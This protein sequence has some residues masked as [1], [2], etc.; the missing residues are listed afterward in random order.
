MTTLPHRFWTLSQ[1]RLLLA[2]CAAACAASCSRAPKYRCAV[3]SGCIAALPPG[4]RRRTP[5]SDTLGIKEVA[6]RLS[7][8]KRTGRADA[9]ALT[10]CRYVRR[11][12]RFGMGA[13]RYSFYT[14]AMLKRLQEHRPDY[15]LT[16]GP[17]SL[18]LA[19][20][21]L[22]WGIEA[23]LVFAY[24]LA[25]PELRSHTFVEAWS[26]AR[27]QWFVVDPS[28]GLVWR[29]AGGRLA[30]AL[31]LQDEYV[32]CGSSWRKFAWRPQFP[33]DGLGE[34]CRKRFERDFMASY[35]D[36]LGQAVENDFAD[37]RFALRPGPFLEKF[38]GSL[39]FHA[40]DAAKARAHAGWQ[41]FVAR[42]GF[43]ECP[44]RGV[45]RW[46]PNQIE[47]RVLERRP[48]EV[49]VK[50][51]HN[52]AALDH[53]EWRRDGGPPHRLQCEIVVLPADRPA[54]Y[55]FQGFTRVGGATKRFSVR[56]QPLRTP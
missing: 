13:F 17:A 11:L 49:V 48:R 30:D 9:D 53:I 19:S 7:S 36:V 51:R 15:T 46:R 27:Q 31:A 40:A 54:C 42:Y 55:F 4:V 44:D 50:V 39:M 1:R 43:V 8:L 38:A 10:L 18:V 12:M 47:L 45:W 3:D 34:E 28:F 26:D 6:R 29:D 5:S 20:M 35:F 41:E 56:I 22:A 52:I 23:R 25:Q 16:C 21:C 32:R 37:T 2:A 14:P 33:A 24:S